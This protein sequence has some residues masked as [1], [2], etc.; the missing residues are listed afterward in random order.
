[1]HGGEGVGIGCVTALKASTL[2]NMEVALLSKN[3]LVLV[4]FTMDGACVHV[5]FYQAFKNVLVHCVVYYGWCLCACVLLSS[6]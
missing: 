3:V 2:C 1:M 6:L 5:Y 4:W